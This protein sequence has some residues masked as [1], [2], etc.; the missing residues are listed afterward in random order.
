[1]ITSIPKI[2][3]SMLDVCKEYGP[4]VIGYVVVLLLVVVLFVEQERRTTNL[5]Q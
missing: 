4:G 3:K 2:F 1:M 5:L